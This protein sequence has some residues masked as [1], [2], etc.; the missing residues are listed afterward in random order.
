M[1]SP[2]AL[3][4]LNAVF[5]TYC[6]SCLYGSQTSELY[7]MQPPSLEQYVAMRK[8]IPEEFRVAALPD[9]ENE[10]IEGVEAEAAADADAV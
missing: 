3:Y 9:D 4:H 5:L 10:D 1:L 2:V 7:H 6:H 8:G